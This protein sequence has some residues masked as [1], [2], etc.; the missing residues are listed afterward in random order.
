MNG[1][2]VF[3]EAQSRGDLLR[4]A[5]ALRAALQL[6]AQGAGAAFAVFRPD[7]VDKS[8]Q[9]VVAGAGISQMLPGQGL[10]R[11]E[12]GDGLLHLVWLLVRLHPDGVLHGT[13]PGL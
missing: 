1:D 7:V 10:R 6:H 13:Q 8:P 5:G 3:A 2:G 12:R 9:V 11:Q 4:P